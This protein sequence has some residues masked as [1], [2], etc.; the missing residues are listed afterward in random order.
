MIKRAANTLFGISVA[1]ASILFLMGL[2][3]DRVPEG[4]C[5]GILIVTFG[6]CLRYVMVGN[7]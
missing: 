4:T 1:L 2:S 7:D 6:W 5:L 3:G